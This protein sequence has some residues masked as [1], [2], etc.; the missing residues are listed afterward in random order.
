MEEEVMRKCCPFC[1][2]P[3]IR[4]A[5]F[6]KSS[7]GRHQRYECRV[8]RRFTIKPGQGKGK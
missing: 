6:G 2:S 8:C 3:K 1:G 4:K 7:T 5:G